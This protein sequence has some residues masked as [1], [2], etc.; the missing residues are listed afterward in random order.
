MRTQA[1]GV[2]VPSKE[3]PQVLDPDQIDNW[4]RYSKLHTQLYPYL[5][6]ALHTYRRTG[7]PPVRGL[8]LSYPRDRTA[9]A[10]ADEF[11]FGADLL[12]APVL[13]PGATQRRLY[14]P[15]GRWVD[16]WRAAAYREGPGTIAL[17]R[18]RALRGGRELTVPAPLEE[19]P[20][21][22]RA[23]AVLA[24]L[25]AKVDTLASYGRDSRDIETLAENRRRLRLLA[26][27][28]GRSGSNFLDGERLRS[29]ETASGWRLTIRGKLRRSIRLE[30]TM[31]TLRRPFRPCAL[32][33]DGRELAPARWSFDR[34]RGVLRARLGGSRVLTLLVRRRCD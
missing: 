17:R 21:M 15:R 22:V 27:P 26:F 33:L 31:R 6:G 18:A 34:G 24:L 10:F 32:E 9:A 8:E 13:E 23:G 29:R 30:A 14:L 4:R 11:L 25:P 1:N 5:A 19:L 28:R 16:L 2:A 7:L 20:L 3:R 12:A